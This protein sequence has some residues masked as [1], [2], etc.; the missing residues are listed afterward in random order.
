M[1][2]QKLGNDVSRPRIVFFGV[3]CCSQLKK[4]QLQRKRVSLLKDERNQRVTSGKL[5]TALVK[6]GD[7]LK[8]FPW[9]HFMFFIKHFKKISQHL[10]TH[11]LAVFA[12][13][14]KQT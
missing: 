12:T 6:S 11:A 9:R 1:I 8:V 13:A 7:T 3:I 5:W 4:Y 14:P 2:F 10:C